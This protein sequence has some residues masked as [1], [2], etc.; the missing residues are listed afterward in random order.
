MK[1]MIAMPL[2]SM[3][4]VSLEGHET[5]FTKTF[6]VCERQKLPYVVEKFFWQ[7]N[8][9]KLKKKCQH[10]FFRRVTLLRGSF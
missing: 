1:E 6:R 2:L 7:V 10:L 4:G 5:L 8:Y 3:I 9:S